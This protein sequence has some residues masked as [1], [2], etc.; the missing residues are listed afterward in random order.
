MSPVEHGLASVHF[1]ADAIDDA[2]R[3][4]L[5]AAFHANPAQPGRRPHPPLRPDK[6]WI[7][8]PQSAFTE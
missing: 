5:N 8:Q 7:N 1:G 3:T 2:R 6:T 4:I